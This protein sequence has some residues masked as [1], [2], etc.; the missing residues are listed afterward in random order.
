MSQIKAIAC[1]TT[2][3]PKAMRMACA[4]GA[5]SARNASISNPRPHCSANAPIKTRKLKL[6]LAL[7]E[8]DLGKASANRV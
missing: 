5:P 4:S 6:V 8:S 1:N 2:Q 7:P 3:T